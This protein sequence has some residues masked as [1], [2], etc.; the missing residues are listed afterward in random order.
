M[1]AFNDDFNRADGDPGADYVIGQGTGSTILS[2]AV[3]SAGGE[4]ITVVDE[5][6]TD[7]RDI[8]ATLGA[9]LSDDWAG[10]ALGAN[11]TTAG[12][13]DG[14]IAY[15]RFGDD[16]ISIYQ[17][18]NGVRNPTSL[19]DNVVTL[20]GTTSIGIARVGDDLQVF[21][22]GVQ[23]GSNL[24]NTTYVSGSVGYGF[25]PGNSNGTYIDSIASNGAQTGPT[26]T[27]TDTTPEDGVQQTINMTGLTGP[28]TA[29]SVGGKSILSLLSGTDPTIPVTYTLDIFN[30]AASGTS[31][32]F[33]ELTNLSITATG[34]TPTQSLTW[35]PATGDDVTILAGTLNK[36]P[37]SLLAEIDTKLGV[38]TVV[39]DQIYYATADSTSITATGVLTSDAT[40]I[41]MWLLQGGDA[42]NAATSTP[43]VVT[44]GAGGEIIV[45]GSVKTSIRASIRSSVRAA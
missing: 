18:D 16:R 1:A 10:V 44:F 19:V 35:Q 32:R 39:T 22:N 42:D 34:G 5:A 31:P 29:A 17:V 28:I 43:F 30:G 12:T 24:T 45:T 37:L 33:K 26:V 13:F 36:D 4:S 25:V 23:V 3:R 20:A 9:I 7:D 27:Q 2:N 15:A 38:T 40:S 8:T 6:Y 21:R 11:R 14:Y 41:Q